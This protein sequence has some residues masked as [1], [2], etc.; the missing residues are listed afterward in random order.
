MKVAESWRVFLGLPLSE[1]FAT[2]CQFWMTRLRPS[3]P[4]VRWVKPSQ[5][6]LTLHFFGAITAGQVGEIRDTLAP[7]IAN[8]RPLILGI[9]GLGFFPDAKRPRILWMGL[10]GE[11]EKLKKLQRDIEEPLRRKGYPIEARDFQPHVTIGRFQTREPLSKPSE[12]SKFQ[13]RPKLPEVQLELCKFERIHLYRSRLTPQGPHYDVLETFV[14]S[15][16]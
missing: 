6:H 4:D 16:A 12:A 2:D 11:F 8:Y 15:Q 3:W 7:V 9:K 1:A 14:L 13:E 5:V 10:S